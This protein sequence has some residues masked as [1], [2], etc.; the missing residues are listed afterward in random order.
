MRSSRDGY[1]NWL[2]SH[3]A[4]LLAAWPAA[5]L[6][7]LLTGVPAGAGEPAANG[8]GENPYL[9]QKEALDEGEKLYR[10]RC[11][12]CHFR[13][14]GRGPNVFQTKL[15]ERQFVDIVTNGGRAGMPAWGATL[16]PEEIRKLYAFVMSRGSL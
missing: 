11:F 14:G 7:V 4:A 8:A 5:L 3:P 9:G 13:A 1:C 10:G 16:S 15:S 6:I 12:G 2:L